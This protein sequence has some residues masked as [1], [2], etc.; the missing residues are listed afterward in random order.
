[1]QIIE[2]AKQTVERAEQATGAKIQLGTNV[3]GYILHKGTILQTIVMTHNAFRLA[4]FPRG[5]SIKFATYCCMLLTD[6]FDSFERVLVLVGTPSTA[7]FQMLCQTSI[8]KT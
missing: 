8:K 2:G 1:M 3:F 7:S 4:A 5:T 6:L